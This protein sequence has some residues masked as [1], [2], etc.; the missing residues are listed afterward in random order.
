[1]ATVLI[2]IIC[3]VPKTLIITLNPETFITRVSV[4]C[5]TRVIERGED[6][7]PRVIVH[8]QTRAHHVARGQVEVRKLT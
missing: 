5:L 8:C 3:K 6:T 2:V 7:C 1:M 4:H